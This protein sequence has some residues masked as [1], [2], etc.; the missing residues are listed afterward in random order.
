MTHAGAHAAHAAPSAAGSPCQADSLRGTVEVPASTARS[1]QWHRAGA[2]R[3]FSGIERA[4]RA[5]LGNVGDIVGAYVGAYVGAE[6][7]ALVGGLVSPTLVGAG[8]GAAHAHN[9]TARAIVR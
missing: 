1:V 7:G 9:R 4:W 6:V 5:P 2:I 3:G 8:V